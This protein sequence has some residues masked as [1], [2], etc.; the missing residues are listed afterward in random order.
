MNKLLLILAFAAG[1]FISRAQQIPFYNHNIINPFV[2]NPAMA[3]FSGD[4]NT[5][6]VRNQR[7]S[8][9]NGGS[10][11]NYLT[12]EGAFMQK[13]AGIGLSVMHQKQGIQ[14]QLGAGVTYAYNIRL[15]E[16][17][18]LRFGVTAGMLDNRID[19]AAID[20]SQLN[21]PYLMQLRPN[22]T[23]FDMN[24]GL[25]YR[26]NDLRIGVSVPQIIGNKVT[27]DKEH[28]RGYYQLA[29]HIMGS[30]EYNFHL[31]ESKQLILKPQAL[32]RYIP[33]GAPVQYDLTAHLEHPR[34]GWISATYK[35]DY[36]VQFNAGIHIRQQLHVGFSYEYVTG[37]M[38]SY[39]SGVNHELLLGYTFKERSKEVIRTVE[40][41]D[42]IRIETVDRSEADELLRRNKELEELLRQ[43][44]AE[45]QQL[46]REK[47]VSDSLKQLQPADTKTPESTIPKVVPPSQLEY[48]K[49]YHFIELDNSTS[50]DGI[51]VISGVFASRA[52]AD[53]SL[54]KNQVN[55]PG[56]Y[57]VINQKNN[58]FYIVIMYTTDEPAGRA[59]H[60]KYI[61]DTGRKAWILK[62]KRD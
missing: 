2:Y 40:V 62:Y 10:I 38:K 15:T 52:N 49:G 23:S 26:W 57:L 46:E 24:A 32:V 8:G 35:S 44:M 34:F 12:V 3:G 37:S 30:A 5:Y 18:D 41:H 39:S 53:L 51:Y 50:P 47:Q 4:V 22:T 60:K 11:N 20:V 19:A 43:N 13:K 36:A 56:A 45:K 54:A 17:Q 25:A 33:G 58:F 59:E 29:R 55:Y 21:D 6:F 61:R 31:L 27:Y 14:Q 16:N 28:S 1:T 42:T 7:Y 9:F 48:A